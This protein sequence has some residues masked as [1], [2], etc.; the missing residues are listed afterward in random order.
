MAE[1]ARFVHIVDDVPEL[2][3][4]SGG[5]V[6]LHQLDG[7]LDAGGAANLATRHLLA[8]SQGRVVASFEVPGA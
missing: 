2:A 1:G 7:F 5:L 4:R 8:A 3:G 6:L